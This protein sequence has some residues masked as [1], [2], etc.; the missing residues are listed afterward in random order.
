M[1]INVVWEN[2]QPWVR[3]LTR[4]QNTQPGY[5]VVLSFPAWAGRTGIFS[6]RQ[7]IA[8]DLLHQRTKEWDAASQL[9][10][11]RQPGLLVSQS[12]TSENSHPTQPTPHTATSSRT[13][14]VYT[15]FNYIFTQQRVYMLLFCN[16]SLQQ[17]M[18]AQGFKDFL[19]TVVEAKKRVTHSL[20]F[21]ERPH[22]IKGCICCSKWPAL[23]IKVK[24]DIIC[25]LQSHEGDA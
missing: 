21:I 2:T 22:Q 5:S 13:V 1:E 20:I 7:K 25:W 17:L 3:Q 18:A 4:R 8:W 14:Q 6:P 12:Y 16:R 19:I 11:E 15:H 23:G 9:I 24:S 10:T